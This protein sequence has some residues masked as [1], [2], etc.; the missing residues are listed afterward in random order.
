M[1]P[2]D[3]HP[4]LEMPGAAPAGSGTMAKPVKQNR[5]AWRVSIGQMNGPGGGTGQYNGSGSGD[6]TISFPVGPGRP[7]V[8]P[9]GGKFGTP[10]HIGRQPINYDIDLESLAKDY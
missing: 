3:S 8:M 9:R 1:N 5:E 6:P 7:R 2:K 4:L 10:E